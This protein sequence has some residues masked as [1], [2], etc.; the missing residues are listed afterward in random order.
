M[1]VRPLLYTTIKQF[2]VSKSF[3]SYRQLV[4]VA[5]RTSWRT[6]ATAAVDASV[7]RKKTVIGTHSGTFHCDEAL[8]CYLVCA[9][10]RFSS[11]GLKL[12]NRQLQSLLQATHTACL[13]HFTCL[14]SSGMHAPP[15]MWKHAESVLAMPQASIAFATAAKPAACFCWR[16]KSTVLH[17]QSNP[18]CPGTCACACP[19]ELTHATYTPHACSCAKLPPSKMLRSS[20]AGT[21]QCLRLQMW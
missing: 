8:G 11:S 6:M 4:L 13:T 5:P 18:G 16:S 12:S 14:H 17:M 19:S 9:W 3:V 20:A 2:I 10:Q 15:S 7:K 21:Q 1:P